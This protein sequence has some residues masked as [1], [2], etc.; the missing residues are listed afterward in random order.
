[1]P[2]SK[3]RKKKPQLP[4][5]PMKPDPDLGEYLWK[6]GYAEKPIILTSAMPTGYHPYDCS[7]DLN[8]IIH[9]PDGKFMGTLNTRQSAEVVRDILESH[10]PIRIDAELDIKMVRGKG[11]ERYRLLMGTVKRLPVDTALDIKS[12]IGQMNSDLIRRAEKLASEF[13]DRATNKPIEIIRGF[14][15]P[16]DPFI[17]RALAMIP[18]LDKSGYT[19]PDYTVSIES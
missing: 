14:S 4:A 18:V 11:G 10:D 12:T 15:P 3:H 6:K 13:R 5:S 19:Y 16:I 7:T 17:I 8:F 9:T 1:M 2:K